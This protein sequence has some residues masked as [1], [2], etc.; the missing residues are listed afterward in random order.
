VAWLAGGKP[1]VLQKKTRKRLP[2]TTSAVILSI[3]KSMPNNAVTLNTDAVETARRAALLTVG[4]LQRRARLSQ[5]TVW[6]ARTG[7]P[8]GLVSA[9]AIARAL[10]VHLVSLVAIADEN[11]RPDQPVAATG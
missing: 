9:R 2:A 1:R 3:M 7:R 11:G 5:K 4:D 10:H 8:I 6:L